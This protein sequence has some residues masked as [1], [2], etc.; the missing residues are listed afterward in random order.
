MI[1]FVAES[2]RVLLLG[3][4]KLKH[5]RPLPARDL[6][7][8][9]LW[10]RRR[11]YAEAS[12]HPWLILSA[13]HGLLDP[14]RCI[15]PYDLTLSDLSAVGRRRWGERVVTA[16][17]ERFGPLDHMIFEVHAGEA[18]RWAIEPGVLARRAR[19]EAPLAG[20]PLGAQLAWYKRASDQAR[21]PECASRAAR[22]CTRA[23]VE[24]CA[25][26]A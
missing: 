25:S 13:M 2:D 16:L 4:V 22:L 26:S 18:Y 9:P 8:S 21:R 11:A 7:R 24:P 23:E 14:D 3:C 17:V 1:P 19:L 6:Y 12:G 10:V 5:A 20:L 15:G